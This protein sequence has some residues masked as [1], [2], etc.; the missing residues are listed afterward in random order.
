MKNC[1]CGNSITSENDLKR[2]LASHA[3]LKESD[4][5][6][7]TDVKCSLDRLFVSNNA[8]TKI[9]QRSKQ[10]RLKRFQHGLN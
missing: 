1:I 3:T 5:A 8:I 6:S 4:W 2:G 9:R 10:E 7:L